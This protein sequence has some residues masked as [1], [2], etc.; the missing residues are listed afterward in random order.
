[1]SVRRAIAYARKMPPVVG[2]R[3]RNWFLLDAI[4]HPL[5]YRRWFAFLDSG[6]PPGTPEETM[7]R[8]ALRPA[9]RFMRRWFGRGDKADHLRCHIRTFDAR[10]APDALH[11]LRAGRGLSLVDLTGRSGRNYRVTVW[12]VP[13]KE[14]D[15]TIRLVDSV[16]NKALATLRGTFGPGEDGNITFWIG[17]LQGV[18]PPLGRE[19]IAAATRD[20]NGLRPK[21]AVLHAA[22]AIC[23]WAGVR[24]MCAPGVRNHI[25][26]RWWHM[27]RRLRTDLDGFWSEFTFVR[28]Q[29]GDFV[30]PVPLPRRTIDEVPAKR[31][32]E[33]G[34]RYA[35][36][37]ELTAALSV[38]LDGLARHDK[39]AQVITEHDQARRLE[40]VHGEV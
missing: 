16:L 34:R 25:A 2:T 7:I 5:F 26:Y 20:L 32:K 38:A 28:T 8:L 1:M 37:D 6:L 17:A 31:R 3:N 35:R 29:R 39:P 36:I 11:S 9:R 23:A 40:N 12:V 22:D 14:G 15:L 21:Q 24:T 27:R 19:A 33:W 30:I 18:M 10:F 4:A 13:W